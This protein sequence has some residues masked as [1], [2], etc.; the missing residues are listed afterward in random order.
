MKNSKKPKTFV[1]MFAF[2]IALLRYSPV[3]PGIGRHSA[4]AATARV[5]L[6]YMRLST[7]LLWQLENAETFSIIVRFSRNALREIQVTQTFQMINFF[8]IFCSLHKVAR[9]KSS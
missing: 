5:S 7:D 9:D 2:E 1:H 8:R 4:I 3:I 6:R